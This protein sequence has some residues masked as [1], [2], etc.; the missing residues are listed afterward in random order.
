MGIENSK[1]LAPSYSYPIG[2]LPV[3]EITQQK[4]RCRT[5]TFDGNEQPMKRSNSA[6]VGIPDEYQYKLFRSSTID[7]L[8]NVTYGST[9]NIQTNIVTKNYDY[10]MFWKQE[11]LFTLHNA[12]YINIF[13]FIISLERL[14]CRELP[15]YVLPKLPP[16][17][18]ELSKYVIKA[19]P[20][21]PGLY[22]SSVINKVVQNLQLGKRGRELRESLYQGYYPCS[23]DVINAINH[24]PT[25]EL[26]VRQSHIAALATMYRKYPYIRST[27]MQSIDCYL[28]EQIEHQKETLDPTALPIDYCSELIRMLSTDLKLFNNQLISTVLSLLYVDHKMFFYRSITFY[29]KDACK[30]NPDYCDYI[31]NHLLKRW[32]CF[33]AT[34]QIIAIEMV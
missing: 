32:R 3:T 9:L 30:T 8:P 10:S 29:I 4:K 26:I 28:R 7:N 20:P 25:P 13:I 34:I 23:N 22:Q 17:A 27:I 21:D 2:S 14:K 11:D 31:I 33:S 5:D 19:F 6:P 24:I 15:A 16:L 18:D 1:A 12:M